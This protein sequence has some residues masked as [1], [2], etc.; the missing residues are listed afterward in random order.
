MPARRSCGRDA[1][2]S[3]D[4]RLCLDHRSQQSP[5]VH[6][7]GIRFHRDLVCRVVISRAENAPLRL[8]HVLVLIERAAH[9]VAQGFRDLRRAVP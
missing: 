8:E 7:S 2:R 5:P 3:D 9:V 1:L 4:T 6:G